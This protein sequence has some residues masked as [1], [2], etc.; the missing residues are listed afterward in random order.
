MKSNTV[1]RGLVRTSTE[2]TDEDST[3]EARLTPADNVSVHY[4]ANKSSNVTIQSSTIII[5]PQ[6]R[7]STNQDES[8][9]NECSPLPCQVS[10]LTS[11]SCSPL[12]APDDIAAGPIALPVQPRGITFPSTNFSGKLRSFTPN[13]FSNYP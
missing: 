3:E 8:S 1:Q 12:T 13:W 4:G 9:D 11:T 10:S 2:S 7:R 5:N 6:M